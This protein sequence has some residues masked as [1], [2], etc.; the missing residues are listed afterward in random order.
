MLMLHNLPIASLL[1][2]SEIDEKRAVLLVTSAPAWKAVQDRLPGL[3]VTG[4]AHIPKDA[5]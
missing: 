2:F 4:I 1:P 5:V 3:R